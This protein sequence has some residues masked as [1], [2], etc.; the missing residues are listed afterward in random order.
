VEDVLLAHIGLVPSLERPGRPVS[1]ELDQR[2]CAHLKKD[3]ADLA[4][5]LPAYYAAVE[6]R[7]SFISWQSWGSDNQIIASVQTLIEE[8]A[9]AVERD[10]PEWTDAWEAGDSQSEQSKGLLECLCWPKQSPSDAAGQLLIVCARHECGGPARLIQRQLEDELQC[11]VVIGGNDVNT[12]RSAVDSATRGVVLLQTQSVLREPVRLLQLFEAVR[13]RHPLVC[14]NVVG[15]GYD[16]AKVKP[17][18]LSLPN[19]LSQPDMV[20][21]RGELMAQGNVIAHLSGSLSDAVPNAISVFFNPAASDVMIEAAIKDIVDKLQRGAELL[22]SGAIAVTVLGGFGA[23]ALPPTAT[24]HPA[25]TI[26]NLPNAPPLTHSGSLSLGQ[27][28]SSGSSLGNV[29]VV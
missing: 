1:I 4:T 26:G 12:W 23:A 10:Q 28:V 14:V 3:V 18:L 16:F 5:W 22:K 19:E 7:L 15:G 24:S 13:Q 8:C 21:L 9:L 2:L 11:E 17:L 27:V 20:T 29:L 6:R 25:P